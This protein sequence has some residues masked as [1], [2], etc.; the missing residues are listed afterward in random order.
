MYR[1]FCTDV[2]LNTLASDTALTM[3]TARLVPVLDMGG[4]N[5]SSAEGFGNE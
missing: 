5:L 1:C 4:S 2:R 3:R